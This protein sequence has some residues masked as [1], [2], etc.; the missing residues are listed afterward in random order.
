MQPVFLQQRLIAPVD[1]LCL[2][3]KRCS[4]CALGTEVGNALIADQHARVLWQS[5]TP[6]CVCPGSPQAYLHLSSSLQSAANHRR[7]GL[8][9]GFHPLF[10][11]MYKAL[12][13]LCVK[14]DKCINNRAF[15]QSKLCEHRIVFPQDCCCLFIKGSLFGCTDCAEIHQISIFTRSGCMIFA[16][17]ALYH[18]RSPFLPLARFSFR[19]GGQRHHCVNTRIQLP[20]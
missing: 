15:F 3:R 13:I 1:G 10:P 18:D 12:R 5:N 11:R 4:V 19:L 2:F 8:T 9:V 20:P 7:G 6:D 17:I 14:H 16:G